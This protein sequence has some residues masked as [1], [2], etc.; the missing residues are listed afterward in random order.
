MCRRLFV[1]HQS[2]MRNNSYFSVIL[3]VWFSGAFENSKFYLPNLGRKNDIVKSIHL[4]S[5]SGFKIENFAWGGKV[6]FSPILN[7]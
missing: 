4:S 6:H 5:W 7:S 3:S 2:K 1:L